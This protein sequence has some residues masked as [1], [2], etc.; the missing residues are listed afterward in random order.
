MIDI[1]CKAQGREE[2]ADDGTRRAGRNPLP[3]LLNIRRRVI[4]ECHSQ[5]HEPHNNGPTR[6][7]PGELEHLP[8]AHQVGNSAAN[9]GAKGQEHERPHEKGGEPGGHQDGETPHLKRP[10]TVRRIRCHA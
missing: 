3:L 7:V 2:P 5:G 8:Q 6:D 9:L 4:Q 10:F 1:E